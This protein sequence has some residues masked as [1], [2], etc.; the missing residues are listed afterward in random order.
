M[1]RLRLCAHRVL[2]SFSIQRHRCMSGSRFMLYLAY[3]ARP[4]TT[5]HQ[6][7]HGRITLFGVIDSDWIGSLRT[8][9]TPLG[10]L[11]ESIPWTDGLVS[12]EC[13]ILHPAHQGVPFH[14]G[15]IVDCICGRP[16]NLGRQSAGLTST[17]EVWGSGEDGGVEGYC[18]GRHRIGSIYFVWSIVAQRNVGIFVKCCWV[19]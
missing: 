17:N 1:R 4:R 9:P 12:S 6:S 16:Y 7:S 19:N 3:H 2:I 10:Q 11:F 13:G 18:C 15:S 8:S 5:T 14:L